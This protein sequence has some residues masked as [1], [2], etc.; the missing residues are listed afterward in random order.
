[1]HITEASLQVGTMVI[2][3]PNQQLLLQKL[4]S[5]KSKASRTKGPQAGGTDRKLD[6]APKRSPG[7]LLQTV[8]QWLPDKVQDRNSLQNFRH[9]TCRGGSHFASRVA[10]PQDPACRAIQAHATHDYCTTDID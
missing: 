3:S 9:C 7:E 2:H 5:R 4:A 1:M 6:K 10:S 8:L